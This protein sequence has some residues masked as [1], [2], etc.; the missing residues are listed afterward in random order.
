MKIKKFGATVRPPVKVTFFTKFNGGIL[1]KGRFFSNERS[2][3]SDLVFVT[4]LTVLR[5]WHSKKL[6]Y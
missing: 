4:F 1:I 3:G 2:F 5:S 6:T